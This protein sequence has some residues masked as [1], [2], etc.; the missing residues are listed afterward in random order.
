LTDKQRENPGVVSSDAGVGA[1]E[2]HQELGV[3]HETRSIPRIS[4][5]KEPGI[6]NAVEELE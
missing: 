3:N 2:S 6:D 4:E 5:N 1:Q